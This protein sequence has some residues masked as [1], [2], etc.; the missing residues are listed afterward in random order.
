M[1]E[2]AEGQL[3]SQTD[4]DAYHWQHAFTLPSAGELIIS[5]LTGTRYTI[6]E[7]FGQGSFGD[8]FACYDEWG[9]ELVA[10]IIR[11]VGDQ[12]TTEERAVREIAALA[13]VR[14]PHIVHVHDAVLFRGAHYII[15]ERCGLT[16]RAMMDSQKFNTHIWFPALVKAILHALHFVYIQGLAHCD[17]HAG[18]VFLRIIEDAISPQEGATVFKLGDFGLARPVQTMD[19]SGTFLASLCPPEAMDRNTFGPLDHRSDVYQA[20]LLFLSVLSGAELI[21]TA[22]EILEGRPR[23]FA[24]ALPHPAAPAI[25]KMLRRHSTY[26][27]ATALDAWREIRGLLA[28]Q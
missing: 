17:I 16:L 28:V 22:D 15:A 25:A 26:R 5:P 20:G 18:N 27:P 11:P 12:V 8:V 3:R 19:P 10:K 9:H 13:L 2:N 1:A 23:A 6:G 7:K 14:S 24:E 21:F 4:I